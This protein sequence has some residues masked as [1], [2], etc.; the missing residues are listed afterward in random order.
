M[1]ICR[2]KFCEFLKKSP[3][4]SPFLLFSDPAVVQHGIP[5]L[6]HYGD[7]QEYKVLVMTKTGI[8]LFELSKGMRHEKLNMITICKVAMQAVRC[9][10]NFLQ[11]NAKQL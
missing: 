4:V 9:F 7:F 2:S 3:A 10:D 8:D 11:A 5:H 1:V 6:M